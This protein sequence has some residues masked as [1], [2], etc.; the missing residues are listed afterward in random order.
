MLLELLQASNY[1][2]EFSPKGKYIKGV[3]PLLGGQ[4]E[5]GLLQHEDILRLLSNAQIRKGRAYSLKQLAQ[6]ANPQ[7]ET[8][9]FL[10]QFST[11]ASRAAFIRGYALQCPICDLDTWYALD[12]VAEL[13]TCQGCRNRFQLALELDFG[14]RPNQ[15]LMEA[16]KSGALTILLTLHHWLND[17]PV[18][19]WQS[20]IEI[21]QEMLRTDIDLLVQREDGLFMA[22]C[23]DNFE[24]D[25]ASLQ[26]LEAQ[27]ALGAHIAKEIGA[28]FSFATLTEAEIPT[29]LLS[30][31]ENH[32]I[33]L[34]D[35]KTLLKA[36]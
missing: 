4:Y 18:T 31:L 35:R 8:P 28:K 19:I 29:S 15:L 12:E 13:V 26:A 36:L 34:I 3:L 1:D 16:L 6:I 17:S 9:R 5:L 23:K 14:F 27:L 30:F 22:E 20:N 7:A 25:S 24:T 33:H 2:A 11:L 10:K 21:K 32:E